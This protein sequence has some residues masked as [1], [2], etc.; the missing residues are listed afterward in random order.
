V[1]DASCTVCL[2]FGFFVQSAHD[3][4]RRGLYF[5]RP[6]TRRILFCLMGISGMLAHCIAFAFVYIAGVRATSEGWH[7][8]RTFVDELEEFHALLY[9]ISADYIRSGG[10]NISVAAEHNNNHNSHNN[11]TADNLTAF[12]TADGAVF[13]AA[14]GNV[15]AA[16]VNGSTPPALREL[17]PYS[18]NYKFADANVAQYLTWSAH[19][20]PESMC[21]M[22]G[23]CLMGAGLLRNAPPSVRLPVAIEIAQPAVSAV[24]VLVL[25]AASWWL[26]QPVFSLL[27]SQNAL[28]DV[29]LL[30]SGG[31]SGCACSC[32]RRGC[33]TAAAC[34]WRASCWWL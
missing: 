32:S 34:M 14:D 9:N 30:S 29:Y 26:D 5:R 2:S 8:G 28:G 12:W 7:A 33:A 31:G 21:M 3:E 10:L 11:M 18:A 4:L 20:Y 22:W 16:L 24:A 23:L 25:C 19:A 27:D 13:G 6:T 15:S 17:A 1:Y